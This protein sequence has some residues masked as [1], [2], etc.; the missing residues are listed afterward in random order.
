MRLPIVLVTH[1]LREARL[2]ADRLCVLDAGRT[3]QAGTPEHVLSRPRNARVADLVGLRDIHDGV[4]HTDPRTPGWG[5]LRWGGEADITLRVADKG[6]VE[7]GTHGALGHRRRARAGARRSRRTATTP[8]PASSSAQ[9]RLGEIT[10]LDLPH[11]GRAGGA[12][13][14][15]R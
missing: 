2:L 12:G 3:L 6:K 4:F 15:A 9:R 11:R 1:D 13:A 8:S 10:T 7:D 14:P 5:W